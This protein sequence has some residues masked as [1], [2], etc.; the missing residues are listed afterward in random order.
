MHRASLTCRGRITYRFLKCK[1]V[2]VGKKALLKEVGGAEMAGK[3]E[4]DAILEGIDLACWLDTALSLSLSLSL[5]PRYTKTNQAARES[6]GKTRHV[7]FL[8]FITQHIIISQINLPKINEIQ[9][10]CLVVFHSFSSLFPEI[11]C[12]T[13]SVPKK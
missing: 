5:F 9:W 2:R 7:I 4:N 11:F 10:I 12:I 13:P 8:Q 3:A 6:E 1:A